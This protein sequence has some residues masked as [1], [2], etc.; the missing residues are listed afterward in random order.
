MWSETQQIKVQVQSPICDLPGSG[1]HIRRHEARPDEGRSYQ[2]A[3][4][5][6]EP[7]RGASILWHGQVPRQ[8]R[9]TFIH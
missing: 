6:A 3:R 1:V 4:T 7:D 5:T 9:A 8:V 2:V